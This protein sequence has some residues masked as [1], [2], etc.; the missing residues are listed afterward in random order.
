MTDERLLRKT[1]EA[2]GQAHRAPLNPYRLDADGHR[3]VAQ[4]STGWATASDAF[5]ALAAEVKRRG[6]ELPACDCPEGS[7][8]NM[9]VKC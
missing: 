7:H 1:S 2:R 8:Y 6:F 9:S 5:F 4:D 3:W